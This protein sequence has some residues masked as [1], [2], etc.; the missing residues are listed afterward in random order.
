M[1]TLF[2]RR[3]HR[4][5]L[6]LSVTGDSVHPSEPSDEVTGTRCTLDSGVSSWCTPPPSSK[7][8]ECGLE[9][10]EAFHAESALIS[11]SA[12]VPLGSS[13]REGVYGRPR[14]GWVDDVVL[15]SLSAP[16][17]IT[18]NSAL[19]LLVPPRTSPRELLLPLEPVHLLCCRGLFESVLK[20]RGLGGVTSPP[21][22]LP[23]PL[24]P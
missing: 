8:S 11:G 18:S 14:V 19:A 10:V 13:G 7:L 3:P 24:A 21:V 16:Q 22:P 17:S 2:R 6:A 5:I 12:S 23:L 4:D 1:R 20:L 9:S 15:L